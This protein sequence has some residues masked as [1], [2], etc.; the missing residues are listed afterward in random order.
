M[1]VGFICKCTHYYTAQSVEIAVKGLEN[2]SIRED[3]GFRKL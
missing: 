2:F 1:T 3:I